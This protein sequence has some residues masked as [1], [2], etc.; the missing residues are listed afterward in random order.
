MLTI[1]EEAASLVRALTNDG[2]PSRQAGLRIIVDP[3]HHSLSMGIADSPGSADS[4]VA[5]HGAR[6]FL[7]P[8]AS[9]QLDKRT[10]RASRSN[11]R[12]SFFLD[13]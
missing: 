12:S 6:L 11:D 3:I 5:S 2:D 10:L 1:S 7:S 13:S 4:V 9:A 8:S